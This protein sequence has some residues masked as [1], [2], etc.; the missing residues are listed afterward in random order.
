VKVAATE[1]A[2]FSVAFGLFFVHGVVLSDGGLMESEPSWFVSFCP[3]PT[4]PTLTHNGGTSW[5]LLPKEIWS[6]N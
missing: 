6:L 4:Q 2:C 1:I 3:I 5:L